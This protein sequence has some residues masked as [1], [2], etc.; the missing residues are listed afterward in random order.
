[1]V[2]HYRGNVSGGDAGQGVAP[3]L[4]D[5]TNRLIAEQQA[6]DGKDPQLESL[7]ELKQLAEATRKQREAHPEAEGLHPTQGDLRLTQFLSRRIEEANLLESFHLL[8]DGR[9]WTEQPFWKTRLM[10]AYLK[11]R[12][13][14]P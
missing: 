6:A 2:C 8:P 13:A 12:H 1:V 4:V 5:Q 14:E 10:L 7:R 9:P 11:G 3:A